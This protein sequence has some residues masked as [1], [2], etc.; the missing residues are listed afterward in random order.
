MYMDRSQP[1][2]FV[3]DTVRDALAAQKVA[4]AAS[5][6]AGSIELCTLFSSIFSTSKIDA[7]LTL[8]FSRAGTATPRPVFPF[9]SEWYCDNVSCGATRLSPNDLALDIKA[10]YELGADGIVIWGDLGAHMHSLSLGVSCFVESLKHALTLVGPCIDVQVLSLRRTD[11]IRSRIWITSRH[12]Q[13][14]W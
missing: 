10:P 1:Q 6:S 5:Q 9:A 3:Q 8:W 13:A 4:G 12:R 7:S 2:A 11:L 14:R